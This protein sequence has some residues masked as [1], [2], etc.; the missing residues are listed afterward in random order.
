MEIGPLCP[1]SLEKCLWED[2]LEALNMLMSMAKGESKSK[3]SAGVPTPDYEAFVSR[4]SQGGKWFLERTLGNTALGSKVQSISEARETIY[5][6][7]HKGDLSRQA[8]RK[9]K[10]GSKEWTED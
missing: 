6:D 7:L 9:I 3:H 5:P 4:V 10:C 8:P 1:N 2:S